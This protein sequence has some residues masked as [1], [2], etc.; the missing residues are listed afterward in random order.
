MLTNDV[1]VKWEKLLKQYQSIKFYKVWEKFDN[2]YKAVYIVWGLTVNDAFIPHTRFIFWTNTNKDKITENVISYLYSLNCDYKSVTLD[3]N[4]LQDIFDFI[5][6]SIKL[7]TTNK[8]LMKFIIDGTEPFNREMK[9]NNVNDF[10]NTLELIPNEISNCID[11]TFDFKL[12]L[13]DKEIQFKLKP[14][15]KEWFL[16][17]NNNKHNIGSIK[18]TYE[19]IINAINRNNI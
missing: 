4:K 5:I 11:M 10:V 14:I 15:D 18:N 16:Y 9:L 13:N 3:E 8:E 12:S 19:T 2:G 17:I 7:E 6:K 1:L